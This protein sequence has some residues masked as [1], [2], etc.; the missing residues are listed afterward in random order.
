VRLDDVTGAGV[1]AK[2]QPVEVE[3]GASAAAG[4]GLDGPLCDLA[5]A[6]EGKAGAGA[7]AEQLDRVLAALE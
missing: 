4:H 5:K 3:V 1:T 2:L 7:V 6:L